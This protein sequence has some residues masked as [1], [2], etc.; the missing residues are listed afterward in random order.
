MIRA[1]LWIHDPQDAL[2]ALG[3]ELTFRGWT[4]QDLAQAS[5]CGSDNASDDA[6]AKGL[7]TRKVSGA[8]PPVLAEAGAEGMS[9]P[10]HCQPGF[11]TAFGPGSRSAIKPI[12][13]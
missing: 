9:E 1:L 7:H 4:G 10:P 2:N 8:R 12:P 13:A 11:A 3:F 6:G 5:S